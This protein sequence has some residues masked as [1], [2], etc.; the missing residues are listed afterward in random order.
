[1]KKHLSSEGRIGQLIY[2]YDQN[3][4]LSKVCSR[5]IFSEYLNNCWLTKDTDNFFSCK[6]LSKVII[7]FCSVV[8]KVNRPL[9]CDLFYKAI[10]LQTWHLFGT[11][12]QLNE[13]PFLYFT[14][15]ETHELVATVCSILCVWSSFRLVFLFFFNIFSSYFLSETLFSV[16]LH[17]QAL[18]VNSDGS[19]SKTTVTGYVLSHAPFKQTFN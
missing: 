16:T 18:S 12:L 17:F 14:N 5:L 7:F 15:V 3:V 10:F 19:D 6:S 9:L 13:T 8:S 4:V 2:N 11:L 1:M